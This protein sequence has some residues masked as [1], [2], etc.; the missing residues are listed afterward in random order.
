[1]TGKATTQDSSPAKVA[2]VAPQRRPK[3]SLNSQ[4]ILISVALLA[5]W[6]IFSRL[7]IL[8]TKLFS[9][10]TRVAGTWWTLIQEGKYFGHL[11]ITLVE[12]ALATIIFIAVGIIF[13]TILGMSSFT[14]DVTYGPIA[15]IFAFPKVTLY[16]ILILALGL[17]MTSKVT[18]GAIFGVFPLI[19]GVM[20]AV[21]GI[22]DIQID[23][24][25]SI[26][27]SFWFKMRHLYIPATLPATISAMRIGFVYAG[28]GVLLAE[29]FAATSGLGNRIVGAGGQPNLDQFWVYV[30]TVFVIFLLGAGALRVV[31]LKLDKWRE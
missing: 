14:F 2:K 15:T 29:M 18:F 16:P 24:M 23:L 7:G 19:M 26:G 10:P 13:G 3:M 21:R 4:V 8:N 20:V 31:E 11:G 12:L 27:S 9:S 17:G 30:L 1:M 6:E 25:H 5:A 22:K 28:I